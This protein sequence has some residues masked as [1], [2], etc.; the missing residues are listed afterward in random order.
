MKHF[1]IYESKKVSELI[2]S[3]GGKIINNAG[4][5]FERYPLLWTYN[6]SISDS[7]KPEKTHDSLSNK[8][9]KQV[10][11]ALRHAEIHDQLRIYHNRIST[12]VHTIGGHSF[13][14]TTRSRFVTG[15]GATHPSETGFRWDHNLGI[16]VIPSS[17]IK[18]VLRTWYRDYSHDSDILEWLGPEHSP[19]NDSSS[20]GSLIIFDAIPRIEK[21]R[22]ILNLDIMNPHYSKYYS[23]PEKNPPADYYSPVPIFFLTVAPNT[24]F[25]FHIAPRPNCA[26]DLGKVESTIHEALETIGIGAKTSVGYGQFISR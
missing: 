8:F 26:V 12:M 16:P 2:E 10:M 15:L 4:L 17:S 22:S 7:D 5:F 23:N 6:D 14:L 18:G 3:P 9:F 25:S 1:A 21:K 20:A 24:R 19:G 13:E 11:W